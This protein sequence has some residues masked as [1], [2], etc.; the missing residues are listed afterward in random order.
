MSDEGGLALTTD[1]GE[2]N[3]LKSGLVRGTEDG[4]LQ[5]AKLCLCCSPHQFGLV[6]RQTSLGSKHT[7]EEKV[8]MENTGKACVPEFGWKRQLGQRSGPGFRIITSRH[9][10]PYDDFAWLGISDS[11][12]GWLLCF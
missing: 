3:K 8:R 6:P 5:S 11:S 2:W 1:R 12:I 4:L 9:L 7:S 10:A